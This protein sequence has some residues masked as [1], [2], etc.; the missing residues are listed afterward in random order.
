MRECAFGW[1]RL[2]YSIARGVFLVRASPPAFSVMRA[3]T[4]ADSNAGETPVPKNHGVAGTL[5][6][7]TQLKLFF[8]C[9]RSCRRRFLQRHNLHLL[10]QK[11]PPLLQMRFKRID[12]A[13]QFFHSTARPHVFL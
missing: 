12:I 4:P 7:A 1:H 9:F 8:A 10:Q 6:P 11:L 5:T 3:S 2:W 13:L